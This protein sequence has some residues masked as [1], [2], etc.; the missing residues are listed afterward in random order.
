MGARRR[1]ARCGGNDTS[2][3]G[4]LQARAAAG[5]SHR[6]KVFGTELQ[7]FASPRSSSVTQAHRCFVQLVQDARLVWRLAAPVDV[8]ASCCS[9][10]RALHLAAVQICLCLR[11]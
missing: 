1:V 3:R 2:S 8:P 10:G 11:L 9:G 7:V 5:K 4:A 6:C